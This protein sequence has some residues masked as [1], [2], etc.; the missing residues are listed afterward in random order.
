M[1][2]CSHCRIEYTVH[3]NV[4]RRFGTPRGRRGETCPECRDGWLVEP[5]P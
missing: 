3:A 1:L 5:K 4:A 2:L